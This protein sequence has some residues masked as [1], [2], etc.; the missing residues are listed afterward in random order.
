M[1]LPPENIKVVDPVVAGIFVIT[2]DFPEIVVQSMSKSA[3][4]HLERLHLSAKVVGSARHHGQSNNA[5]IRRALVHS[6][7]A[8]AHFQ[9]P[10]PM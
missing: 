5:S 8:K 2:V 10:P 6:P 1:V 3:E 7:H 4:N 9:L